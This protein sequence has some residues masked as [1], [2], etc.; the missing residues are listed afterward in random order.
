MNNR[1]KKEGHFQIFPFEGKRLKIFIR[2]CYFWTYNA[3]NWYRYTLK[4]ENNDLEVRKEN[5]MFILG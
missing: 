3:Y 5:F 1:E 2:T 4:G